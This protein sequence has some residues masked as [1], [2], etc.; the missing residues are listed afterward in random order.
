MNILDSGYWTIG[1]WRGIPIR[2]HWTLPLG[3]AYFGRSNPGA[4]VGFV[5]LILIHELGHAAIVRHFRLR[6]LEVA[7]AGF[8]GF[9]RWSGSASQTQIAWIAWGGVAAQG[10]VYVVTR[11][12]A[13]LGMIPGGLFAWGL[14]WTFTETNLW[15]I[16]FNLLPIPPLDGARAWSIFKL[17]YQNWR[18]LAPFREA[19]RKPKVEKP[20]PPKRPEPA[21]DPE[22][23]AR[24][25][26]QFQKVLDGLR[27]PPGSDD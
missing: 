3:A 15:L 6:V 25:E 9:C 2:F 14:F 10:V 13:E 11:V 5:L 4:W 27:K 22:E 26:E 24:K 19:R 16:G 23:A 8:G 18:G 17:K 21:E 7:V 20:P 12:L 1:K